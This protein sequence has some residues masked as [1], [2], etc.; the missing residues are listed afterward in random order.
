LVDFDTV[1]QAEPALDLGQFLAYLRLAVLK[2][3]NGGETASTTVANQLCE[4]FL[5]TYLIAAGYYRAES[6]QLHSRASVYEVVSLLRLAQHSW[7]KLK[8]SRLEQVILVL[9]E[10]IPCLPP[11]QA[12]LNLRKAPL[13][14]LG[15][16]PSRRPLGLKQR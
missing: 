11:L 1:C 9:E 12:P 6:E 14:W 10:R 7:Q 2:A 8:E 3:H 4:R 5:N 16:A 13:P 15:G